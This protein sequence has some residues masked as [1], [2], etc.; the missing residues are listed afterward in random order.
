[1]KLATILVI[2]AGAIS[3]GVA[4]GTSS[5]QAA[6]TC[7]RSYI[8][9][10]FGP[11]REWQTAVARPSSPAI[12]LLDVTTSGAGVR[13]EKSFQNAMREARAAGKTVLGYADTHY[14]ERALAEVESNVRNYR[15]WYG[16]TDIMLDEVSTS[17][18]RLPY[19]RTL[20]TYIHDVDHGST[21]WL[22]P[23]TIPPESYMSLG[24][25]VVDFEGSYAAYRQLDVPR[26]MGD[27]PKSRFANIVYATS[28]SEL[29]E[30][31]SLSAKNG[32]GFVY[33]TDGS[34]PNPYRALPSY[35]SNEVSTLAAACRG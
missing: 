29:N 25:V 2:V 3:V 19:Y 32:A 18:G 8:P 12:V 5:K 23:G 27:Y 13:P 26:W 20:T 17:V 9:A 15:S 1:M 28:G 22:N 33:I 4:L 7:S 35:W 10:F 16:I 14:G 31:L 34:E 24:D 11:G 21:V 6:T 30:A